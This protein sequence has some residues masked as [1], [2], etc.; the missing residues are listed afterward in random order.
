MAKGIA[1]VLVVLKAILTRVIFAA[2]GLV[3][4]WRVTEIKQVSW[5]QLLQIIKRDYYDKVGHRSSI[6][7]TSLL[8]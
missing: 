2:H 3:A 6:I 7:Q 8:E 5:L 4:I 1:Q